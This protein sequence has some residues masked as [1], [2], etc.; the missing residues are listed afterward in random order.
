MNNLIKKVKQEQSDKAEL[1]EKEN[2]RKMLALIERR[3]KEIKLSQG[4]TELFKK[5]KAK[6]EKMLE[7]RDYRAL[8][9]VRN[10]DYTISPC[11]STAKSFMFYGGKDILKE[12]G[13]ISREDYN[14]YEKLKSAK[15]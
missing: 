1:I 7:E 6:L 5:D 9:P 15:G 13:P 8:S 3:D 14:Y 10:W 11:D 12:L 4:R 2:I